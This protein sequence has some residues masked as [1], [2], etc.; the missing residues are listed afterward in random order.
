MGGKIHNYRTKCGKFA[1]KKIQS[2]ERTKGDEERM[3]W[4]RESPPQSQSNTTYPNMQ[5]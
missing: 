5:L 1:Q 4:H 2:R 3:N